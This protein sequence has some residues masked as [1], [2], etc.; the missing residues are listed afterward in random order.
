VEAEIHETLRRVMRGRTTLLIA[1]R[2]STLQLAQRIA[3]LDAGRLVDEGSHEELMARC[4]LYRLLLARPGGDAEGVDAGEL[5]YYASGDGSVNGH[6]DVNGHGEVIR[7]GSGNGHGSANGGGRPPPARSRLWPADAAPARAD[8]APASTDP[9]GG[10]PARVPRASPPPPG[11][12]PRARRGRPPPTR[13]ASTPGRPG[14][15][16]RTSRCG[17]CCGH[18]RSRSWSAWCSTASTHWPTSPCPPW[19]GAGSTTASRRR[20]SASSSPCRRRPC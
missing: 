3:V 18:S 4:P 20:P 9:G 15:R 19:S 13:P 2:R 11:R 6:G 16:T 10:L 7:D 12:R 14:R 17:G 1:H 8:R 5:A